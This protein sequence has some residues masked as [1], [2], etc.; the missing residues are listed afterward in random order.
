M[1]AATGGCFMSEKFLEIVGLEKIFISNNKQLISLQNINLEVSNGEFLCIVGP[2]G[3]GKSTLLRCIAGFEKPSAGQ[4]SINGQPIV[5]PDTNRI[6]VFQGFDQLFPW[7]TV[8][9]NVLFAL[10][11]NKTYSSR[12]LC[13]EAGMKVLSTVGLGKFVNH[14]PHQLSGGMKQRAAIARAIALKPQVLL[15]DEPFA[16][17]DAQ[18]RRI[19]QNEL[20]QIW[21]ALG[22]TIIFV[23]HNIEEAIILGTRIV[24]LSKHP[25]EIKEIFID[26]LARPR[27]ISHPEFGALWGKLND[28]LDISIETGDEEYPSLA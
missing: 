1:G 17:L 10:E 24:V 25:G 15:M 22:T 16:S 19:L 3:C 26:N 13:R 11:L 7:K 5:K 12:E 2:S 21:E 23:T 4:M 9:E 18:T 27:L 6:M 14:Y 28:C 20:L 8:I